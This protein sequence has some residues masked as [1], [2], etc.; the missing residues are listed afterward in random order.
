MQMSKAEMT[1]K[2][3]CFKREKH[4]HRANECK[5]K[6]DTSAADGMQALQFEDQKQ[7]FSGMSN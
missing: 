3:L 7:V 1:K 6:G 2:G 5:T 4:G